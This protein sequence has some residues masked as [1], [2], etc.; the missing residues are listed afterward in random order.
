M[1]SA[2]LRSV[3][4]FKTLF[5]EMKITSNGIYEWC[6]IISSTKV[7]QRILSR[8]YEKKGRGKASFYVSK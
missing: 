3:E 5:P 7:I 8:N 1:S 2:V 6:S 4:E